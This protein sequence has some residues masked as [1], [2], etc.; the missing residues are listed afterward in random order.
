MRVCVCVFVWVVEYV[1]SATTVHMKEKKR[2]YVVIYV[3]IY[4]GFCVCLHG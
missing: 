3:F 4:A 1:P 2:I